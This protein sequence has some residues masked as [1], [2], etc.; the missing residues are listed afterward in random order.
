MHRRRRRRKTTGASW[1]PTRRSPV[2]WRRSRSRSSHRTRRSSRWSGSR[3]AFER[4]H[5]VQFAPGAIAA[6]VAWSARYVPERPLPDKAVSVLDLAGARARR[7]GTHE[8]TREQVADVR[9]R[10]QRSARRAPARD[11]R[12]RGCSGS[13]S[14]WP[15]RIVGHAEALARIARVLRRNAG[16]F[17]SRPPDRVVPLAR[18][19]GGRQDGDGEGHRRVPVSLA[20]RHDAP[21]PLRVR[22]VARHRAPRRRPAWVRGP[23]SRRAA[24]RGGPQAPVSGA[25]AR[26]DREGAPGRPRGVLAALRRGADDRRSRAHGR[27]HQCRR[28][29]DLEPR[30]GRVAPER[31]RAHRLRRADRARRSR[32]RRGACA[33]PPGRRFRRSSTTASTR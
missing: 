30:L 1:R 32:V 33:R 17:R 12:Q 11:G 19:D 20:P 18:P 14:C 4:H 3:P 29:H 24:H 27:L 7:R 23:R 10:D 6:A 13:S 25:P 22:R 28:R 16:G 21:R 9:E 8:V 26:R 5:G 31:A 2:A 15:G